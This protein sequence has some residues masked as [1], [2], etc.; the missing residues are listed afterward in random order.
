[1]FNSQVAELNNSIIKLANFTSKNKNV[2]NNKTTQLLPE[3]GGVRRDRL[4]I[5]LAEI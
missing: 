5:F 1:M 4:L 2:L 3:L